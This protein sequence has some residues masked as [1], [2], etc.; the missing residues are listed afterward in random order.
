MP[1]ERHHVLGITVQELYADIGCS[2][3]DRR[4]KLIMADLKS[5]ERPGSSER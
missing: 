4:S 1:V 2:L 5:L 3:P